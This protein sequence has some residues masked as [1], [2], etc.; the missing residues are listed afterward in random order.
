[1]TALHTTHKGRLVLAMLA[2][3]AGARVAAAAPVVL[4]SIDG[5]L[6]EYYLDP[7]K[8]GL[9]TPNLRALVREGA[10]ATGA[11]SVMPTVTFPAH[12]TMITGASPRR[13]GILTNDIFDPDGAL[14]GGWHWY[15]DD[16][17]VP[18]LFD[19][20]RAARLKTASVTWPVTAGGPIDLN[21]PDMYPVPNLRE[22]KNLLSLARASGNEAV[23]A[24]V[25]PP[26]QSLV[27]MADDLRARVTVRFLREKPELLAV[28]FLELDGTQHEH[29][30][31]TPQALA[32]LERIDTYLGQIFDALRAE[33]RWDEATVVL[34]SDHGFLAVEHEVRVGVLLRTLGLVET[35][36]RGKVVSWRAMAQPAGAS[37]AIFLHRDATEKDRRK[38]DDAVRLLVANPAYGVL[39]ALRPRELAAMGG[40]TGAHVVL[41]ARPSFTFGKS[42]DAGDLVGTAGVRGT[43]GA[44]PSRPELRAGFV[45]RGPR[46]RRQK[47]LGLVRL[48]DVAPTIARVLGIEMG[49]VEGRVIGEAFE[50][51]PGPPAAVR[52]AEVR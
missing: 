25:L 31:R 12:T 34:V 52:A 21:L 41:E 11:T 28:H 22:A 32:T 19:K 6:P 44:H 43:H 26:A 15:Y 36:A 17:K 24:E 35:D 47:N 3:A 4:I 49:A 51:P 10:Y 48:L 33:R 2:M 30:P 16:I 5:L 8:Y 39:R 27:R 37:A 50:P 23:L 1:M 45:I 46:V 9:G 18:T 7:D 13:H 38:V 29:G 14:G 40:F 20:A 42:L